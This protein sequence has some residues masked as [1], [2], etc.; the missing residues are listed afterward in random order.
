M[1]DFWKS[2]CVLGGE[3]VQKRTCLVP[4]FKMRAAAAQPTTALHGRAISARTCVEFSKNKRTR[5]YGNLASRRG[6][7][8]CRFG[9]SMKKC[10]SMVVCAML[11]FG[12]NVRRLTSYSATCF[13]AVRHGI[14]IK[15]GD[16]GDRRSCGEV[17]LRKF[18]TSPITSNSES[19]PTNTSYGQ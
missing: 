10:V 5:P 11:I 16:R 19:W 2:L 12:R 8:I 3:S 1:V 15:L 6:G 9:P 4:I 17:Y 18:L 7:F 13:C 14:P